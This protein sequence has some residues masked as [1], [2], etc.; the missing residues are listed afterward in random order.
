[1]YDN[2]LHVEILSWDFIICFVVFFLFNLDLME[3]DM[4]NKHP[5]NLE[6]AD[7]MF[8]VRIFSSDL[9]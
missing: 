4:H 7:W 1:M 6:K 5:D 9:E 2:Y 8:Y 3:T